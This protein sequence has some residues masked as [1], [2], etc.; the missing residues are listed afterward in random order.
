[1]EAP[2]KIKNRTNPYFTGGKTEAFYNIKPLSSNSIN[3]AFLDL[4][5]LIGLSYDDGSHFFLLL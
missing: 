3:L 2:Q 1:M 5:S 4:L